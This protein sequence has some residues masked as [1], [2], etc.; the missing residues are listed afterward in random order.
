MNGNRSLSVARWVESC[1]LNLR[2][3]K[4]ILSDTLAEIYDMDPRVLVRSVEKNRKCF[5]DDFMFQLTEEEWDSLRSKFPSRENA[6]LWR[7]KGLPFAFNDLG[8]KMLP[9]VFKRSNEISA[10]IGILRTLSQVQRTDELERKLK[11]L[12]REP[13]HKR[14]HARRAK[15]QG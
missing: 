7:T 3:Q 14:G 5:P 4:V 11:I 15:W 10:N 13:K 9:T 1:V 6:G 8:V 2:G 12:L